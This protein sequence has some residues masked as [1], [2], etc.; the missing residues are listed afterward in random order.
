MSMARSEAQGYTPRSDLI[1]NI[2]TKQGIERL[3]NYDMG[4]DIH[5]FTHHLNYLIIDSS[6]KT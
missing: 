5:I 1:L 2:E 6:R 4:Y 3:L